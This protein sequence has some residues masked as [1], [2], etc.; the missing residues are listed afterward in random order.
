MKTTAFALAC[1]L[2]LPVSV[3]AQPRNPT[4]P[5]ATQPRTAPPA[6]NINTPS[7]LASSIQNA[8][9]T[10]NS[11]ALVLAYGQSV[12]DAQLAR[13]TL[14]KLLGDYYALR[15]Q[16]QTADQ[17]TQAIGEASLRFQV[18]Q[19]AQNQVLVQ[20][21]QILMQQN[22]RIIELLQRQGGGR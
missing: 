17:A 3:L 12:T 2:A 15:N 4:R 1:V 18:F 19:A 14:T 8:E 5:G 22:Q 13:A 16:A 20:Q 21:N 9:R 7:G 6:P 10:Q 11:D